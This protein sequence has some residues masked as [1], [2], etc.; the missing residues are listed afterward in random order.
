MLN[1]S[2]TTEPLL[3]LFFFFNN[4]SLQRYLTLLSLLLHQS[5]ARGENNSRLMICLNLL[6]DL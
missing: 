4:L 6:G 1:T 2:C 3:I 5:S